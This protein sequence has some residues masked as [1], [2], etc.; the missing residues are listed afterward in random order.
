[1]CSEEINRVL[2]DMGCFSLVFHSSKAE[3]WQAIT[4]AFQ[5]SNFELVTSGILDKTQSSF[6]QV[7]SPNATEGDPLMLLRKSQNNGYEKKRPAKSGVKKLIR[8]MIATAFTNISNP[9]ERNPDRLFSRSI[10][11]CS[12][13]GSQSVIMDAKDLLFCPSK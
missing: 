10:N 1:M 4:Q 2:K 12:A 8:S 5:D 7:I 3:I 13:S 6:K 11:A 9:E